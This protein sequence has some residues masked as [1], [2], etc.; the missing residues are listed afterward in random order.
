MP[1]ELFMSVVMP[2]LVPQLIR[3]VLPLAPLRLGTTILPTDIQERKFVESAPPKLVPA[4]IQLLSNL[5]VAD[6]PLLSTE[7]REVLIAEYVTKGLVP[8]VVIMTRTLIPTLINVV[9]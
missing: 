2:R 8:K 5:V 9:P 7:C 4:A 6:T 1:A 3:Q